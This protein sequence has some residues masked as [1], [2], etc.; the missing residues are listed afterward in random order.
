MEPMS[1][2]KNI[3]GERWSDFCETFTTGNRGRLVNI[4]LVSEDVGERLSARTIFSAVD[5]DPE[6]KK[7]LLQPFASSLV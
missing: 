3:P 5:Y 1:E 4:T 7:C 6:E 2:T